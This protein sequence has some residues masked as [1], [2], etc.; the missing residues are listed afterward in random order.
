VHGLVDALQRRE[1]GALVQV[2]A[3]V[4]V[5]Q[6]DPRP[7]GR[8]D[9]L[10]LDDGPR[11][12]DLCQ[13]DV[14]LR[15]RSVHVHLGRTPILAGALHAAEQRLREDGL[16]LLREQLGLFDGDVER[17]E[18]RP[19]IDDLASPE[20]DLLDRARDLVPQ[21]D[22]AQGRDRPDRGRRAQVLALLCDGDAHLLHRFGL[23]GGSRQALALGRLLPSGEAAA[24]PGQAQQQE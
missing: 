1:R 11:A 3:R 18:Q 9:G 19:S 14:A 15:T 17:D 4:H 16:R 12:R 10:A 20:H 6:A 2:L 13:S 8:A 5:R 22:R 24:D 21:R 7:E 23:G